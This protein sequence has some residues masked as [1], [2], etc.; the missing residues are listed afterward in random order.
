MD[1]TKKE[2]ADPES[3]CRLL[4]GFGYLDGEL[5]EK[6]IGLITEFSEDFGYSDDDVSSAISEISGKNDAEVVVTEC[7]QGISDPGTRELVAAAVFE[8]C[9]IDDV[10]HPNEST[11]LDIVQR[12]WNVAI[13]FVSKPIQWDDEQFEVIQSSYDHRLIV[14]AGPGMGK[15]AVACARVA[16]LIDEEGLS[17]NNVWMISFTRAAVSE[18]ADR[19][20]LFS[21]NAQ[22]VL[23]V[24][25]ATIDSHAWHLRNGFD[26]QTATKLF[27]GFDTA[28]SRAIE[29]INENEEDYADYFGEIEHVIID[30]AQDVNGV[31]AQFLLRVIELLSPDCGITVFHDPAQ[32]IYDYE[33]DRDGND[34]IKLVDELT[35]LSNFSAGM[36][37]LKKIHRTDDP[38]LLRL[39]EDLRLDVLTEATDR[40]EDQKSIVFDAAHGQ[41][42]GHFEA[43][44]LKGYRSALVL[45]RRRAQAI[46][47]SS[48]MCAEG[49]SH[50]LRMAGYPRCICPWVALAFSN[51]TDRNINKRDFF[52]HVSELFQ[53][54][55]RD[56]LGLDHPDP[57]I[58]SDTFWTRARKSVRSR[59][60]GEETLDL[61]D[62]AERLSVSPIDGLTRPEIGTEGP[63]LGTIHSSKGREAEE[64]V[65][66]ISNSWTADDAS[67]G[68]PREEG[69]VLF[70][71]ASRAKKRLITAPGLSAQY[72]RTLDPSGRVFR[73]GKKGKSCQLQVGLAND[74]DTS[75]RR[76]NYE[77]GELLSMTLPLRCLAQLIEDGNDQ[78]IWAL[79]P[80]DDELDKGPIG[81]FSRSFS[82]DV[83]A[84][85]RAAHDCWKANRKIRNI[86]V[87]DWRTISRNVSESEA[88]PDPS[89]LFSI[90]PVVAGFPMV[91]Y[92]GGS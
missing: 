41:I 88:Q 84:A 11:F 4:V 43:R 32:S 63:I 68:D 90:A 14:S 57:E 52:A 55:Q 60:R 12:N 66:N 30:E 65:L 23:G 92:F 13:D 33:H 31:R 78:W 35:K 91:Y 51:Q 18:L 75:P 19:I 48:F 22:E 64:V 5:D 61:V 58:F 81:Y 21:E 8:L 37:E 76:L 44:K 46:M 26:V 6:E 17:P 42:P 54:R 70:V 73:K 53:L 71:G 49:I 72:S 86:Y 79:W 34:K 9:Q 27:G 39:Y 56:L 20:A 47:A 89:K 45:F 80:D 16:H 83:M 85:G 28:I 36:R 2:N 87:V 40:F 82:N 3:I 25:V 67:W 38:S 62:L 74:I 15:T 50:R 59:G 1:P 7:I 29:M 77:I 24:S 69:R 10:I